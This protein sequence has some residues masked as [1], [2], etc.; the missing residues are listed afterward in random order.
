MAYSIFGQV[1][2]VRKYANGN[3]EIDLYHEDEITEYKYSSN[4]NVDR[5]FPKELAET[6]AS[7]LASDICVG[8]YFDDNQNP[9]HIELEECDYDDED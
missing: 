9:T 7:T 1:V 4:S 2:G 8:I 3:I 6:L 5:N